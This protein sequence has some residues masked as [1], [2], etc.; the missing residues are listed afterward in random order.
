MSLA[1]PNELI[2]EIYMFIPFEQV[3][4]DTQ[5]CFTVL[6]KI[7]KTRY[8]K[9]YHT[10]GV[11]VSCGDLNILKFLH[12]NKVPDYNTKLTMT[13]AIVKWLLE[14]HL[15]LYDIGDVLYYAKRNGHNKEIVKLLHEKNEMNILKHKQGIG[16][17]MI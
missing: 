17:H 2:L 13:I 12:E 3:L 5:T 6:K 7:H 10:W 15:E 14:I 4:R 9:Y 1:L 16:L 8:D 11:S